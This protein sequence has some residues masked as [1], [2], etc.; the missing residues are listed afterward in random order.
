MKRKLP[1]Y[2]EEG[3][4]AYHWQCTRL[5]PLNDGYK[6]VIALSPEAPKWVKEQTHLCYCSAWKQN[7]DGTFRHWREGA[8]REPIRG[9]IKSKP[10][11]T[12]L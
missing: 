11:E 12:R 5:E 10:I 7:E 1:R 2:T 8:W 3:R 4:Y 6:T 9:A